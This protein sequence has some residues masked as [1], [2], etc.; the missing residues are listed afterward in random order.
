[1][2][3]L[4]LKALFPLLT[5]GQ[6]CLFCFQKRE[7]NEMEQETKMEELQRVVIKEE[8]MALVGTYYD[9]KTGIHMRAAFLN[10]LIFWQS[11]QLK[12][13]KKYMQKIQRAIASKISEKSLK[14]MKESCRDGWFYKTAEDNEIELMGFCSPSSITR[15]NKEFQEQGWL[16]LG[17]N[18]DPKQKYDRSTWYRLNLEKINADLNNLGYHLDGFK[19][20]PAKMANEPVPQSIFHGESSICHDESSIFHGESSICHDGRTI[21]EGITESVSKGITE[22]VCS[23]DQ[24][25]YTLINSRSDIDPHTHKEIISLLHT[26]KNKENFHYDIF[27]D[28]LNKVDFDIQDMNYFKRALTNNL[29]DGYVRPVKNHAAGSVRKELLPDWFDENETKREAITP[30]K[31]VDQEAKKKEIEKILNQLRA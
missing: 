16:E 20:I 27:R 22:S 15:M 9:K 26:V 1:M 28:T 10:N 17:K 8:L 2:L 14:K 24:K 31:E 6:Q 30:K 21:T 18:P 13:D 5:Y 4:H 7:T 23:E 29:K 12:S 25:I 3:F 11:I 19:E